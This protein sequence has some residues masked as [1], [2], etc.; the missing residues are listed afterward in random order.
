MAGEAAEV[1]SIVAETSQQIQLKPFPKRESRKIN[2]FKLKPL[3][4]TNAVMWKNQMRHYLQTQN[5]WDVVEYTWENRDKPEIRKAI[6][7]DPDWGGADSTA[8]LY[9]S[10]HIREGDITLAQRYGTSGEVWHFLLEKYDRKTKADFVSVLIKVTNWKKDPSMDIEQSLQQLEQLVDELHVIRNKEV[11][12]EE[13]VMYFFLQGLPDSYRSVRSAIYDS[14][15][16]DKMSVLARLQNEERYS[17]GNQNEMANRANDRVKDLGCWNCGKKGHQKAQCNSKPRDREDSNSRPKKQKNKD[18]SKRDTAR[19]A[20]DKSSDPDSDSSMEY[21]SEN[22]ARR[23]E[24]TEWISSEFQELI[25]REMA[26]RACEAEGRP[27][28]DSRATSHCTGNR[29]IFETLDTTYR[30]TLGA[31]GKSTRIEG[32]GTVRLPMRDGITARLGGV[33]YVPGMRGTLLST[34]VLRVNGIYNQHGRNGYKF[35]RETGT[36]QKEVIA[37]GI[38]EG[39]TSYLSWVRSPDAL[40]TDP[41][42]TRQLVS[43]MREQANRATDGRINGVETP[44]AM[45]LDKKQQAMLHQLFGHP[46]KG[47]LNYLLKRYGIS[48]AN[49][50]TNKQCEVCIQAKKVKIQNRDPISRASRILERVYIGFWGPYDRV[51]AHGGI[52]YFLSITD[53][54]SRRSWVYLTKDRSLDTLL[55]TMEK[56]LAQVE[57]ETGERLVRIRCDNAKEFEALKAKWGNPKGIQFEFTEAHTPAQNGTAERLNRTLLE[58]VRSLLLDLRI[59]KEYWPWALLAANYIRNRFFQVGDEGS[60]EEIFYGR[61]VQSLKHLHI[62]G[63]KVWYHRKTDGKLEPR[64]REGAFLGYTTLE[65]QYFIL[66]KEERK[67]IKVTNPIFLDGTPSFICDESTKVFD[68]FDPFQ[69]QGEHENYPIKH[70]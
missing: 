8:Q 29:E 25:D 38:D 28:I 37:R 55:D 42:K 9:I 46:G 44:S 56:W 61:R 58:M 13:M 30:G 3:D 54:R 52:R 19:A 1:S 50:V 26:H 22:P 31:A 36:G 59:P 35:Y 27:V 47:R 17:G 23:A 62:F 6:L 70:K 34:Q 7:E 11:F 15:D 45:D 63:S 40:L 21:D 57:R 20:K 67:V 65:S 51:K 43:E 5:C 12:D 53:C 10:Q 32:M 48:K 14:G 33:K 64:A 18:R 24:I 41:I 69:R 4:R 60:P 66:T 39:L 68:D 49:L 2:D 16:L